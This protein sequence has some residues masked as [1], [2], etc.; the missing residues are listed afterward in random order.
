M[1]TIMKSLGTALLFA[2]VSTVP[3]LAAQSS[4]STTPNSE[5]KAAG[6]ASNVSPG[7]NALTST[8][9]VKPYEGLVLQ[10]GSSL[11]VRLQTT[12]TSKTNKTGDKFTGFVEQPVTNDGKVIVPRGSLVDGH[13]VFVK[14]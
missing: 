1:K 13:I 6:A 11:H 10:A 8:P 2:L 5:A 12:L 4:N 7:T 3:V 9:A 14:N